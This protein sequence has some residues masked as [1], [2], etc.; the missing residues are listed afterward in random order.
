MKQEVT[1]KV[2]SVGQCNADNAR[3]NQLIKDNYAAEIELVDTHDEAIQ[4]ASQKQ[5]DLILI[6][7]LLDTTGTSG[8]EVIR[9]LQSANEQPTATMLVSNYEDAQNEAVAAGA[10]AG[11]GKAA[12]ADPAT[13]ELLDKY[14]KN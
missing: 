3:I 8:L 11:F 12:L 1:K 2:L 13:V 4:V 5:F 7:R 9:E 10:V 14:L 6:N